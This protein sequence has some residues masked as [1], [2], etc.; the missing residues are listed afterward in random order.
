MQRKHAFAIL[1]VYILICLFAF[2]LGIQ[3]VKSRN[4]AGETAAAAQ[5]AAAA[6]PEETAGEAGT[7][8]AENDGSFQVDGAFLIV[9]AGSVLFGIWLGELQKKQK[10]S[11]GGSP[12][13]L[14]D[15]LKIRR[16]K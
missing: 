5:Q 12:G 8:E 15:L 14:G 4:A 2:F 7:P 1:A 6:V 10:G 16:K 13:R 3:K 9:A 11:P